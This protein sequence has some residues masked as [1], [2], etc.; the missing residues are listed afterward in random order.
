MIR[1]ECKGLA[2][3]PAPA[4]FEM[5]RDYDTTGTGG[6]ILS[7]RLQTVFRGRR[8]STFVVSL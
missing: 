7:E 1:N 8:E 5:F 4:A 6:Y 2:E 3:T